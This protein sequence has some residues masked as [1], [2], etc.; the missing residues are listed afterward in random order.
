MQACIPYSLHA[1]SYMIPSHP[2][3]GSLQYPCALQEVQ[4]R[5]R[6]HKNVAIDLPWLPESLAHLVNMGQ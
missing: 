2:E 3:V 4:E 6:S 1:F 5:T